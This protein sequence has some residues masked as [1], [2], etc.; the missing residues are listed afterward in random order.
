MGAHGDLLLVSFHGLPHGCLW[1]P[2]SLN[3]L[4]RAPIDFLECPMDFHGSAMEIPWTSHGFH[5]FPMGYHESLAAFHGSPVG[6]HALPWAFMNLHRS[7]LVSHWSPVDVHH[8][9]PLVFRGLQRTSMRLPC[10][11]TVSYPCAPMGL[12]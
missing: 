2:M 7:L 12:P 1:V 9:A 8:G 5:G 4:S 3:V 11:P 10:A 6:F